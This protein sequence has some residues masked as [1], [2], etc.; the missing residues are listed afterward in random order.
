MNRVRELE[1]ARAARGSLDLA[2][3]EGGRLERQMF[4][5]APA[6][7]ANGGRRPGQAPDVR[8]LTLRDALSSVRHERRRPATRKELPIGNSA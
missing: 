6:A 7:T 5:L 8:T 2:A 1:S 3:P 4:A